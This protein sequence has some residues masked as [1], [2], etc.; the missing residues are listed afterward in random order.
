MIAVLFFG[1]QEMISVLLKDHDAFYIN[2]LS[3]FLSD[4]FFKELFDKTVFNTDFSLAGISQADVVVM[5]FCR[6]E[7]FTCIPELASRKR[8][9]LIGIVEDE[10]NGHV[11]YL[12]RC[13]SDIIFVTRNENLTSIR[14]K[15]LNNIAK[16]TLPNWNYRLKGCSGCMR[17]NISPQQVRIMTGIYQ[18][19]SVEVIAREMN[20]SV[21]TVYS[22]KYNMMSKFNLC[23]DYDLLNFLKK[24]VVNNAIPNVFREY[25]SREEFSLC[26]FR[27]N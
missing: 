5:S 3:F 14:N 26:N 19:K 21:K 15:I 8:G 13:F 4:F 16:N 2:G 18:G 24:L 27:L 25:L 20:V 1:R 6:G 22:H 12:P 10:D 17:Q 23:S 9:I 11:G 7:S